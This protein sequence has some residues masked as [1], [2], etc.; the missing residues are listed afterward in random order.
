MSKKFNKIRVPVFRE[1]SEFVLMLGT[2]N[3]IGVSVFVKNHKKILKKTFSFCNMCDIFLLVRAR[4]RFS[5]RFRKITPDNET[6][7]KL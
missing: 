5:D 3:Q 7:E 6:E 2:K 4:K 1:N